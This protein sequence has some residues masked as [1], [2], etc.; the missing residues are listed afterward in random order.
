M[1]QNQ[2]GSN[3]IMTVGIGDNFKSTRGISEIE[4]S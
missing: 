4:Y 1:L 2:Y 3:M